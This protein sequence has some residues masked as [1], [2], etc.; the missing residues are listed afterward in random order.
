MPGMNGARCLAETKR[1]NPALPVL[2]ASGYAPT[3]QTKAAIDRL[4]QGFAG[5]PY[6]LKKMLNVVGEVL[7][8]RG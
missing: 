3:G 6:E 5:K 1:I 8:R 4:A 2:I 7:D